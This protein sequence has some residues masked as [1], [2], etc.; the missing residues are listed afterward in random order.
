M[1]LQFDI[2]DIGI[3]EPVDPNQVEQSSGRTPPGWYRARVVDIFPDTAENSTKIEYEIIS[4]PWAGKTTN[5]F[6]NDPNAADSDENRKRAQQKILFVAHRLGCEVLDPAGKVISINLTAGIGREVVIELQ[7]KQMRICESCRVKC[8]QP[9]V[10]KCPECSGKII[11][12]DEDATGFANITWDGVYP[13]DHDKIPPQVR[14]DLNLPPSR[15]AVATDA[16][17]DKMLGRGTPAAKAPAQAP[18]IGPSIG[19]PPPVPQ[20]DLSD[21]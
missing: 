18:V 21:L 4:G 15:M 12:V 3:S 5:D 11:K 10:R 20:H 14:K 13:P 6:L 16:S 2:G 19:M 9:R 1:E 17:M 7:R 8:E